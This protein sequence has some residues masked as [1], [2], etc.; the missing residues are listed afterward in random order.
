MMTQTNFGTLYRPIFFL[1]T[2][3]AGV[4]A[5]QLARAIENGEVAPSVTLQLF[6]GKTTTLDKY[7]GKVVVLEWFN[8]DCPFVKKH[9]VCESGEANMP[10]LQQRYMGKGVVWLTVNSTAADHSSY[11]APEKVPALIEK[12]KMHPATYVVDGS[13]EV[14]KAF[15]AKTT[16]HLFVLDRSGKVAYQGAIDDNSLASNDPRTANSYLAA[17]L[18]QVIAGKPV[19]KSQTPPYGCSVKYAK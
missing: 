15:G 13:G 14:G 8:P 12:W 10:T 4:V 11:V 19:E 9:Y 7:R 18:D 6:D 16:P 17:A 5:P 2:L 1:M 3:F